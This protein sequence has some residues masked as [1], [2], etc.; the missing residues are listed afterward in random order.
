MN[1]HAALAHIR[2]ITFSGTTV[3]IETD[4][5]NIA[6]WLDFDFGSFIASGGEQFN[7]RIL[8]TV[9]DPALHPVPDLRET[10][11]G[12]HFVAFDYG[13]TRYIKY[14]KEALLIYDYARDE[15]ELI[16]IAEDIAYE[17]LYLACL[18]R[19]GIR[20]DKQGLH[21]VHA[22]AISVDKRAHLFLMP[23]GTGKSTLGLKLL[24]S[25]PSLH[26]VSDDTP[27]INSKGDVLP[28]HFRIGIEN[29]D[30]VASV[31]EQYKREARY[32]NKLK[33][34][35][36]VRYFQSQL[37]S[38]AISPATVCIGFWTTSATPSVVR[39]NWLTAVAYLF[40]DCVIG[41]GIPQV[42]EIFLRKGDFFEKVGIA[43]SRLRAAL[44]LAGR[45]RCYKL[46]LCN[47][48]TKNAEAV[49]NLFSQTRG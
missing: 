40:R 6:S 3:Q 44:A 21:R 18:S 34:L 36:D 48:P 32:G 20:L 17:R 26:L 16:A 23:P 11:R 13:T 28:F 1:R 29:P 14:G 35:I 45:S 46:Y 39:A 2:A 7:V 49:Y 33:T 27:V 42:A 4:S 30:A 10:M 38:N 25:H 12:L 47:D 9:A 8:V 5:I 22:L 15:G 41:F 43:F 19:I 37:E 24:A 31:P